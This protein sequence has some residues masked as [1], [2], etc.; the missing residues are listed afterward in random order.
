MNDGGLEEGVYLRRES[1]SLVTAAIH[2]PLNLLQGKKVKQTEDVEKGW[3][4]Q[5]GCSTDECSTPMENNALHFF[6][7]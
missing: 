2:F 6:R 5:G 1:S 7:Y 4:Y 3:E